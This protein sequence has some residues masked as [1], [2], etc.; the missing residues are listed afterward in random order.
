MRVASSGVCVVARIP[1]EDLR[2][3]RPGTARAPVN[4]TYS[5]LFREVDEADATFVVGVELEPPQPEILED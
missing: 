5:L 1:S 3:G 2:A 4:G